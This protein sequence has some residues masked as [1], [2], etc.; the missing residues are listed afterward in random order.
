MRTQPAE[1]VK[2]SSKPAF[3]A[4]NMACKKPIGLSST[5]AKFYMAHCCHPCLCTCTACV[6]AAVT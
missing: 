1:L 6:K 3:I 5:S 2:P 4:S